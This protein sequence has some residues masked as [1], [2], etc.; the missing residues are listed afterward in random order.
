MILEAERLARAEQGDAAALVELDRRGLLLGAGETCADY[1]AR[2]RCLAENLANMNRALESQGRFEVEDIRVTAAE[3]IP[4]DLFEQAAPVTDDLY[5]FCVDWVP[6]FFVNPAMGWLFGGCAFSFYPDFFAL[7]VI[8]KAFAQ[9][10]R[11]LIYSRRELLAHELCHIARIGLD[12]ILFEE[13]FAYQTATSSFRRLVGSV[14]RVP[15][16]SYILLL[17]TLLLLVGQFVRVLLWPSLWIWPFWTSLGGVMAYLVGRHWRLRRA[18]G[19]ALRHMRSAAGADADA[20]LFR[21]TDAEIMDCARQADPEA[22]ADWLRDRAGAEPRWQ[23]IR[24][25]FLDPS[26]RGGGESPSHPGRDAAAAAQSPT[27]MTD[28]T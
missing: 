18:F 9:R 16:D 10:E 13:T 12:S 4:A 5:R 27:G 19:R 25:R 22:L 8:R 17:V 11:W 28:S 2:L 20:V 21:C 6:G 24:D 26:A 14:F 23:V 15:A 3:R 7:F 1:V